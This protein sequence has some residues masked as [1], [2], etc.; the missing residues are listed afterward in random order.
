[1]NRICIALVML[2]I[3]GIICGCEIFTVNGKAQNFTEELNS[4]SELMNEENFEEAKELS[5]KLLT[6]W[7][8]TSKHL[9]KYL[10][11]DYVDNITEGIATLPVY[12]SAKDKSAVK[13]QVEQIKIKLASLKE[14]ELPYVHNIL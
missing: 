7:K 13:S 11:H 6:D 2:L 1:M 14:S 5:Q 10:Y 9:D 8:K 4:I 3:S 12:T